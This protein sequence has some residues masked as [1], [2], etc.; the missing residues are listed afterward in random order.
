M[1]LEV[2]IDETILTTVEAINI[3]NLQKFSPTYFMYYYYCFLIRT[4]NIRSI[5]LAKYTAQYY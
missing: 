5:L 3:R 4:L 2:F 1:S